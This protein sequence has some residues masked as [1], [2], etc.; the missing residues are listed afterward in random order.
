[1]FVTM[2]QTVFFFLFSCRVLLWLRTLFG[3][4][5]DLFLCL[6]ELLIVGV[7]TFVWIDTYMMFYESQRERERERDSTCKR[8]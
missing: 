1:M 3:V 7:L 6:S 4:S 8:G 5:L 2:A